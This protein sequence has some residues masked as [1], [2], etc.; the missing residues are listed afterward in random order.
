[1][2]SKKLTWLI[3]GCSLGLGISLTRTA[4]AS[5]HTVIST[6]RNPSRTPSLVA[7][8]EA[9]GGKWLQLDVSK[10]SS[11]STTMRSLKTSTTAHR[12]SRSTTPVSAPTPPVETLTD[13]EPRSQMETLYFG[14]LRLI[15]AALPFVR[16]R[17]SGVIVNMSSSAALDGH[18][19][20]ERVWWCKG[21]S[22]RYD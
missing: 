5:G 12:R 2:A 20:Y 17:R 3:T 4:H 21:C 16:Q 22:R 19:D 13:S 1:M 7:E 9:H 15:R 10:P 11:I 14:P 18:T 6:S 8:S